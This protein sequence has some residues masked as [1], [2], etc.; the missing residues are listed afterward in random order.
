ME[1]LVPI[2]DKD[3]AILAI[4]LGADAL[5]CSGPAYSARKA[6][7]IPMDDLNE[8]I[9]YA[10][11]YNRYVYITLNTL[12]QDDEF[13]NV[14][15]YVDELVNLNIDA[16]I[17]QDLGLMNVVSKRYPTLELHAST[18]MHVHN[19]SGVGF[20]KNMNATRVVVPREMPYYTIK[21]IRNNFDIEIETFMHGA[22]C[23]SYSG[24]CYYS[25][26]KGSGSGNFGSC[27]Q[28][29]RKQHSL[30]NSNDTLLSLKDLGVMENVDKL[31]DISD[32][33][34]IEGRLKGFNYL[35]SVVN[36]YRRY[37]DGDKSYKDYEDLMRI[38]FN[39]E[40]T[41]GLIMDESD[42]YGEKRVNNKGL[43]IGDV[44]D[45]DAKY[46]SIKLSKPLYRLDNIRIVNDSNEIGF[47]VEE[48]LKDKNSC[49]FVDNGIVKVKNKGMRQVDGSV[50]VVNT[51]RMEESI[52]EKLNKYVNK[53]RLNIKLIIELGRPLK[54]IVGNNVYQSKFEVQVA[55]KQAMT[56]I[57]IVEQLCKIKDTGFT[58]N[59][60]YDNKLDNLFVP[61]SLLNAFKREI[62]VGEYNKLVFRDKLVKNE[63]NL[64]SNKPNK[65][66]N[67]LY[68]VKTYEQAKCLSEAGI[69]EIIVDNIS[70]LDQV[71]SLNSTIV[72]LLPRVIKQRDFETYLKLVEPYNKVMV[73]ELGMLNSLKDKKE[74]YVNYSLNVI[75]AQSLSLLKEYNVSKVFLSFETDKK[76]DL[77]NINTYELKYGRIPLMVMEYCPI[78]K[79]LKDCENCNAC[80][81]NQYYLYDE[82]NNK[83]PLIKYG[84]DLLELYSYNKTR[85]KYKNGVYLFIDEDYEQV[86]NVIGEM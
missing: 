71:N 20:I 27:A 62:V 63:V 74:L 4:N 15:K 17:V 34:K 32:S 57:E 24:Q 2:K 16:L 40:F 82:D 36:Y 26:S 76:I 84:Y 69:Q 61:K 18:Q 80:Q 5:Y 66:N 83:L 72:P 79:D 31:I 67:N 39:R 14:I 42:L 12:I 10:H 47:V 64:T 50:W 38:S 35:Y 7:A 56:S 48:L 30:N 6:A 73:S 29:C 9:E 28:N 21:K 25:A 65:E 86:T 44:I 75:N 46:I 19:L 81:E 13:K 70:I 45:C 49:E 55:Q 59:V 22:L 33:L 78:K 53:N 43:Y 23:T 68:I 77:D 37:L 52:N 58:F 51:R 60:D 11:F 54:A 8:I 3:S 41:S 1:L 85:N